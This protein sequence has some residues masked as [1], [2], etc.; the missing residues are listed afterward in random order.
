MEI[1]TGASGYNDGRNTSVPIQAFNPA[2]KGG[3]GFLPR[4][5]HLRHQLIANH[6][7]RSRSILINEQE[8]T[9]PLDA[10]HQISCLG[11]ASA[12]ILGRKVYCI[13]PVR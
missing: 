6:K 8:F 1:R 2:D 9:A 3:D 7:V 5:D 10:L 11:G 4:C 13:L 12:G